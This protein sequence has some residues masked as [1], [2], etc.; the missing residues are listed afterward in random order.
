MA[1]ATASTQP[2]SPAPVTTAHG[3]RL[4]VWLTALMALML[5]LHLHLA[6]TRSIN[7]DEFHFLAQ[8]HQFARGELT[9]PLQT[10][11]VQLFA[12]LADSDLSAVDQIVRGRLFM[13][14]AMIGT[15][16]AIVVTARRFTD[17]AGALICALAYLTFGFV[18][19]HGTA[20]RTDPLAAA[21]CMSALAILTR[22]RLSPLAI[23]AAGLALGLALMVTIKMV[24]YAP[25]F[26][27]VAWL[28]WS[29]GAFA[30]RMALRI[31]A[32][33]LMA[34]VAAGALYLWHS[35]TLATLD[36]GADMVGNSGATM[37]GISP[38]LVFAANA[39][40]KAIP[41]VL[42]LAMVVSALIKGREMDTATRL[43]LTGLAAPLAWLI[44]Y[45]NTYPYF[46]A[47]ILPPVCVALAAAMPAIAGRWGL[48]PA[49]LLLAGNGAMIWAVDGPS[50]QNQQ[51]AVEQAVNSMFPQ[52]TAY[53]DFPGFLPRH[54]KANFF[55]TVWG[56]RNYHQ[57][58]EPHFAKVMQER[59]VPLLLAVE[60]EANPSLLAVMQGTENQR[61]FHRDD[62]AALR[63]SYRPVWGPIYLAGTQLEQSEAREWTVRVPGR[64]RVQGSLT[65]DGT[66]MNDGEFVDLS[67]GTVRLR[68]STADAGLIWGDTAAM[69]DGA[70][71]ARPYWR[72]F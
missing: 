5:G 58:G 26:I 29:E 55:M 70:P 65:I 43:A 30:P 10:L 1:A 28:R 35:S 41:F 12:W 46:Y 27:G 39:V 42:L 56:F 48:L 11:H 67:R 54:Q 68:A 38:N 14:A 66:A 62:V 19:Q 2:A 21:L 44:F 49:A 72:G 32:V 8:V 16:A 40:L 57:A 50:T 9:S 22:S 63:D 45:T 64:Y 18:V 71:P 13:F 20:F 7:W 17:L 60:P 59:S 23:G 4:A 53:F 61:L 3:E 52:P 6:L 47:F 25:A 31:V 34:L 24:L 51:R 36:T 69:P 33:A 37:F 15:C